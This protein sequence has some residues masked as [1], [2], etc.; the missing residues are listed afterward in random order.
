M[1]RDHLSINGIDCKEKSYGFLINKELDI[2]NNIIVNNTKT[3]DVTNKTLAIIGGGK[4]DDKLE[5]LKNLSKKVDHIFIA[6]GNI[7]SILKNNME[8]YLHIIKSNKAEITLMIDGLCGSSFEDVPCYSSCEDL[9]KDKFFYDIGM[10]S[11]NILH[12]LLESH[13]TIFWNGTLGVV[14]NEQYKQGSEMLLHLL[15]QSKNKKIIVG[16]GDTGG[17]VNN[18]P[19]NF[20]HVSTGGGA[21]IDYITNNN[22]IGL[23][24]FMI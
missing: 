20:T 8:E 23:I 10:K 13:N 17:F 12:G 3:D 24:Q 5:L 2:L 22:L 7:N 16:G 6:G 9:P 1:H 11:M 4:M 14:E 15:M 21:T 19:H 18:Y